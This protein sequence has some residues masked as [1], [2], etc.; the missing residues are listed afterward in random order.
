MQMPFPTGF[1]MYEGG[2]MFAEFV[3]EMSGGRITVTNN[4]SG[5][6]VDGLK[7]M[8]AVH[9]GVLDCTL[10]GSHYHTSEIGLAGDLFNLYPGRP[11][12]PGDL[13]SGTTRVAARHYIRRCTTARASM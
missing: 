5:A 7:E 11:Q 3:S 9:E 12:P 13:R 1:I 4:P 8:R 10:T 2:N 6:I